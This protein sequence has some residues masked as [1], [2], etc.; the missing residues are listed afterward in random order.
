MFGSNTRRGV[1]VVLGRADGAVKHRVAT[2]AQGVR[3]FR[4]RVARGIDCAG[5]RQS[6]LCVQLVAKF[7]TD[8]AHHLQRLIHHFRPY[9]VARQNSY[10]QFHIE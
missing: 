3:L 9:S 5:A 6:R 8:G 10:L 4:V 2:H 1:V 7:L